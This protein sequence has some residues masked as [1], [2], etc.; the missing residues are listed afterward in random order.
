MHDSIALSLSLLPVVIWPVT[1]LT[2]PAALFYAIRHWKSPTSILP[3]TKVRYL[4][5]D[6]LLAGGDRRL[7]DAALRGDVLM[8]K[9][10]LRRHKRLPG[11]ATGLY[12][13]VRLWLEH[14]HLLAVESNTY[15]ESYQRYYFKDIQGI[16]I[17]KTA[18]GKILNG[19]VGVPTALAGLK[20]MTI[21]HGDSLWVWFWGL[22]GGFL[23]VLLLGNI[24]QGPT[25]VT[26][27]RDPDLT[28]KLP[29]LHRLRTARKVRDSLRFL[30][31]LEQ[32]RLDRGQIRQAAPPPQSAMPTTK[33]NSRAAGRSSE[34]G[35]A[36]PAY[37]GWAHWMLLACCLV[38]AGFLILYLYS[39]GPAMAGAGLLLAATLLVV[40]T[41]ALAKQA[42]SSAPPG[43]KAFAWSVLGLLFVTMGVGYFGMLFALV[44]TVRSRRCSTS[45]RCLS[46][47]HS[48]NRWSPRSCPGSSWS[49]RSACSPR[50]CSGPSPCSTGSGV[51]G[52]APRGLPASPGGNGLMTGLTTKRC[53]R[54][55][56]REA[57]AMCPA[58]GQ[59]F[60]RGAICEHEGRIL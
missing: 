37:A 19:L 53:L 40:N 26:H 38:L 47:W 60:C 57:V 14:D 32:G 8:K 46:P 5:A 21:W 51:P 13:R 44:D 56:Q 15:Q 30:V 42:G 54:H 2:A 10:D 16:L 9:T 11:K 22:I 20:L 17:R 27:I 12:R 45:G 7:G 1:C 49:E 34:H 3:R 31:E 23:L 52:A 58:C 48:S 59:F 4:A 39:N 25:C 35:P 24:F 18:R 43:V 6:P 41:F 36:S 33:G 28:A 55:R 29:S 50:L